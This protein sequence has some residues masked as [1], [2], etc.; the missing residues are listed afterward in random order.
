MDHALAYF[1]VGSPR[2]G[3]SL[4][5]EA[6]A[7]TGVLGRPQEYF[8]RLQEPG[9]ARRLGLPPPDDTNYERYLAAARRDGATPNG[10]F[11]AKLFWLHLQDLLGHTSHFAGLAG[12]EAHD[13]F[14]SVFGP[15]IRGVWLRRNCLR[16]AVSL[17]RAEVTGA[18][19]EREG[20]PRASVPEALDVWRVTTLHAEIHGS[21]TGWPNFLEAA[22]I[23]YLTLSYEQTAGDVGAAVAGVAAFLAVDMTDAARVGEPTLRRQADVVTEAFVEEWNERTGGCP[24]CG[25]ATAP[26]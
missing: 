5:V 26:V 3:S 15:D 16:T 10:V 24:L 20:D 9:L 25:T 4:L 12:L 19:A 2:S 7:S 17:W 8:W 14:R 11:G 23:P 22:R 21:E 13:R 18:W 1:V 6:L